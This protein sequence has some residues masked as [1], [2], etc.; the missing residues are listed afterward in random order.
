MQLKGTEFQMKKASVLQFKIWTYNM[1]APIFHTVGFTDSVKLSYDHMITEMSLYFSMWSL[2]SRFSMI[3]GA[4]ILYLRFPSYTHYNSSWT[5]LIDR[6]L[7]HKN[8]QKW[9]VYPA[10]L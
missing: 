6:I 3:C 10:G 7:R 4:F 9:W 8:K 2:L 1:P 5:I